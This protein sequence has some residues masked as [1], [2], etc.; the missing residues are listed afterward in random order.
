MDKNKVILRRLKLPMLVLIW[1][2][3]CMC[4]SN[5]TPIGHQLS[6]D[7]LEE[8]KKN[9]EAADSLL[10]QNKSEAAL[11]EF[12]KLEKKFA[13]LPS[14]MVASIMFNL[15]VSYQ[16]IEVYDKSLQYFNDYLTF[17]PGVIDEREYARGV[18]KIAEIYFLLGDYEEAHTK[19][20]HSLSTQESV[21]DSFGMHKNLY[22]LGAMYFYKEDFKEALTYFL[23]CDQLSYI[24]PQVGFQV[25]SALGSAYEK[26]GDLE[27]ALFYN[28]KSLEIAT[29]QK[30][31]VYIAY[32]YQNLGLVYLAKG[33]DFDNA[34]FYLNRSCFYF[35]KSKYQRGNTISKNYLGQL[36]ANID[37]YGESIQFYEQALLIATQLKMKQEKATALEG[38]A[39]SYEKLGEYKEAF[40]YFKSSSELR[41]S[42][43]NEKSLD[44]MAKRQ[45][46]YYVE[47]KDRELSVSNSLLD[48][49]KKTNF[50]LTLFSILVFVLMIILGFMLR[51]S[52]K[53]SKILNKQKD[54][55]AK[56]NLDLER[57]NSQ[58]EQANLSKEKVN[59]KLEKTNLKLEQANDQLSN[60]AYV[61]S[62]DLKEPLRT[63]R[64]FSQLILRQSGDQFDETT[65]SH[66][67]FIIKGVNRMNSFV[68]DLLKYSR[69]DRVNEEAISVNIGQVVNE[70]I[71]SLKVK[72]EES[73]ALVIVNHHN[74]PEIEGF[75]FHFSQLFQN[76]MSNGIKFK[77]GNI[78]P[79]VEVNCRETEDNYQF[80][81]KDNG[82]GMPEKDRI[83]IFDMF[84]RLHKEHRYTGTGIGLATCKRIVDF[85]GG[86]IWVESEQ[87]V[88]STFYFTIPKEKVLV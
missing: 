66:F 8:Y 30:S 77:R 67:N 46:A 65:K 59:K 52:I 45:A 80:S 78:D 58:L 56:Q 62:H 5:E 35:E 48:Q 88:G 82:I 13:F 83:K 19:Y 79:V 73:K 68:D 26:L 50:K 4:D 9:Q 54:K 71:E 40:Q 43:L 25:A 63:I 29:S 85:Y 24:V 3:C 31:D 38:L 6:G 39:T 16:Q 32:A 2:M 61:A 70:T 81:I 34:Y 1:V 84:T 49:K 87:G 51:R 27:K 22:D 12:L 47:Q 20:L 74:L 53:N 75:S 14:S 15:G 44:E 69:I 41:D 18:N 55:I 33:N 60:Y 10:V 36:F 37:K 76:I 86:D 28:N 7:I 23:R 42:I 21:K 57:T 17:F 11:K 72:I 64:S